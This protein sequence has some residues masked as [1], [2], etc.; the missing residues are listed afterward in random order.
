[1]ALS[2]I[3]ELDLM[4]DKTQHDDEGPRALL[5]SLI[6]RVFQVDTDTIDVI[7]FEQPEDE[8]VYVQVIRD[9]HRPND[10]QEIEIDL[11]TGD[12]RNGN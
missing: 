12:I 6:A 1:M 2:D 8:R 7:E 10:I 11:R 5:A 3:S 9:K 4:W